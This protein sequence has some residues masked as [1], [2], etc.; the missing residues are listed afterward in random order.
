MLIVRLGGGEG[1]RKGQWYFGYPYNSAG[2][3]KKIN[4]FTMD[5]YEN[6]KELIENEGNRTKIYK[7]HW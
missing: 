4:L 2:K 1:G 6:K 5:W 3:Q 7:V